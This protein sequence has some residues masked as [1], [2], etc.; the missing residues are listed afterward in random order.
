M[1]IMIRCLHQNPT[2]F[3]KKK[4]KMSSTGQGLIKGRDSSQIV[5][6]DSDKY[7]FSSMLSPTTSLGW[8]LHGFLIWCGTSLF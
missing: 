4:D 8:E 7:I 2:E 3:S 6:D 1:W 5:I